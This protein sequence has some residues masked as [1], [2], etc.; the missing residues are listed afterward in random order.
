MEKTNLQTTTR[1][2]L[3][4][5]VQLCPNGKVAITNTSNV[6][7]YLTREDV[8]RQLAREDLDVHRRL[9]YEEALAEFSK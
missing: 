8:S 3:P 1:H 7:M 2:I 4:Y 5:R 6:T 9:M